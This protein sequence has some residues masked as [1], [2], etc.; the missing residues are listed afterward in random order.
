[1]WPEVPG[2]ARVLLAGLP[3]GA[4]QLRGTGLL[5]HL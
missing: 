3:V 4:T 1:M 2:E 5:G